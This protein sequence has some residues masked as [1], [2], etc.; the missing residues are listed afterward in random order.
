MNHITIVANGSVMTLIVNGQ[1]VYTYTDDNYKGG[2]IAL[3]VSN[4]PKL[5]PGAQATF[6]NLAVYPISK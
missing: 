6:K 1:T 5:A 2:S 3:F 4:L